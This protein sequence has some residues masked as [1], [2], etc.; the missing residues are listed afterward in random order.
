MNIKFQIDGQTLPAAQVLHSMAFSGKT[1]DIEG[2]GTEE[3]YDLVI[4]GA[5]LSGLAT[6]YFY[7][8]RFGKDKKILI[9]DPLAHFGGHAS[10]N[11]FSSEA[12]LGYGGSESF[13]S[14]REN[15]SKVVHGLLQVL[16]IELKRFEDNYF[17]HELYFKKGLSRGTFFDKENFGQDKLVTGD[18]TTWVSDDVMPNHLNGKTFETFFNEFPLPEI[19]KKKLIELY[20]SKSV[21]LD[22]FNTA[23]DLET[24][25]K[26][27]SYREFLENEWNISQQ[28]INYF[29][30]KP[31]DFFGLSPS[32][33]PALDARHY[34]FP[35]FQGLHLE[36]KL[37]SA[38]SEP[39]VY[40]FPD[41]NSSLARLLVR[42]LIPSISKGGN[43]ESIVQDKFKL[44]ELDNASNNVRIRLG[45]S[46]VSVKNSSDRVDIGII[47]T[48]TQS[49]HRVKAN[50]VTLACFN[51]VIPYILK[52]LPADQA[53]ALKL[54][55]KVPMI[56]TNVLLKNWKP[57][58][59][60]GVHEIY[61]I[62]TFHSRLKLDYP[63]SLGGY[64]HTIDDNKPIVAHLVHV[65]SLPL[66]K[67]PRTA[68]RKARKTF[69]ALKPE[70]IQSHI[71]KDLSRML[72]P[73]GF[74]ESDILEIC[75]NRWSHGYS[76]SANT[77][78]ETEEESTKLM[79]LARKKVGQ[80]TIA[81]SDSAWS[82][83]AH[84]AIDEA[85]RAVTEF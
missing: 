71:I 5:G 62:N 53:S 12:R 1:F 66:E 18:P 82:A 76:Y 4:A 15:F 60:L 81:N 59:K 9:L 47:Q 49:I 52:D 13:Q 3:V 73:G 51:M 21:K 80:V 25:L 42:A 78:V 30:Q 68:L 75:V 77:L 33:I 34:G 8:Q 7:Q 26:K 65:P 6:A 22:R 20:T 43:T 35:G 85:Y 63:V 29:N 57:W 83:Y 67:D 70:D 72:G 69:F 40:H 41:G 28:A 23:E 74:Q 64:K 56:Y 36:H 32:Q 61:G 46:V 84:S 44:D 39:Y 54:N 55:V 31:V 37:S 14:P 2:L 38:L 48:S 79:E 27:I 16:G 11:E 50:H 58:V 24:Y 10:R 19:D 17:D 45:C